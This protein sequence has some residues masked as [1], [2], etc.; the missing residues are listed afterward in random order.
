MTIRFTRLLVLAVCVAAGF[1]IHANGWGSVVELGRFFDITPHAR[2]SAYLRVSS[3]ENAQRWLESANE[4]LD[5]PRAVKLPGRV[6]VA[7]NGESLASGYV[8]SLRRGERYVVEAATDQPDEVFIDVFRKVEDD[9][10]LLT[11]AG[12]GEQAV[13]LEIPADGEYIV[14]V[15]QTL[16]VQSGIALTLSSEPSLSLPVPG[17]QPKSI[18]S[19]FGAVRD[20]GR[21]SH[22]GVDIFARR[23]TPVTAAAGGLVTSVGTNGLGGNVVWIAR[24]GHGERHYYA[25]LD[26][27]LVSAGQW[28]SPGDV[29]GTVGNTG[30][31][32]TT[33][34]HLHFG[35]YGRRGPVDPLPYIRRTDREASHR[36]SKTRISAAC[37]FRA[38]T[39]T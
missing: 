26:R 19:F 39:A 7:S 13:T 6:S 21:R 29:I 37:P 30:N 32:R 4:A 11:S 2:Y 38:G 10:R 15:Q 24:L 36:A 1:W 25:H 9:V 17:A 31:A 5:R 33:S 20:G 23:G 12:R 14:R 35:I 22:H 18:Q 3:A 28:V 16:D 27:Q 8:V 34:P